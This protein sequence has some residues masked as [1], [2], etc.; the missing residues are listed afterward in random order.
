MALSSSIRRVLESSRI[1]DMN[2]PGRPSK[3]GSKLSIQGR[4]LEDAVQ[5]YSLLQKYLMDHSIAHKVATLKRVSDPDPIQSKKIITVYIPDEDYP[6]EIAEEVYLRL[7]KG[8][9]KG[10][11]NIKDPP[12]YEHYAGAVWMR[13]DRDEQGQYIPANRVAAEKKKIKNKDGEEV[14]IYVYSESE[15]KKRHKEKSEQVEKVRKNIEDLQK[16]LKEDLKD[17]EKQEVALAVSLI[18]QT[19]ERVG[20]DDSADNGHFGVTGWKKEHITFKGD[21]AIIKYTGKSGVDQ[22]REVTDPT[23]VKLLKEK[24]KDLKKDDCVLGD[25]SADKVNSYLKDFDITAKDI[26][27]FHANN[28]MLENLKQIRGKGPK[29]PSDKKEKEKLLKEEF[30]E[31]LEKTAERVGHESATLRKQYLVPHLEEEF[32]KDGTI[33]T[34]LK[35]ASAI[36]VAKLYLASINDVPKETWFS[37]FEI[38]EKAGLSEFKALKVL[39]ALKKKGK[40]WE[41]NGYWKI[42]R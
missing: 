28:E 25:T 3:Q 9:Y 39:Y 23:T 21:K 2:V 32:M 5:A 35:K 6:T 40:V 18:D 1:F 19:Y 13:N 30:K 16:Q 20:N 15:I 33:I 41:N 29:L 31:A 27:G 38:S 8:G 42:V 26:R 4:T 37:L 24:C 34:K 36:R 12:S 17:P 14:D 11:Y 7:Q 10:W 22:E